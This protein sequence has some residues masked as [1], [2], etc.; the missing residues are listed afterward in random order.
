M[1]LFGISKN[2]PKKSEADQSG[3]LHSY[4]FTSSKGFRGYKKTVLTT[5]NPTSQWLSNADSLISRYG[6]E[7]SNLPVSIDIHTMPNSTKLF[8]LVV[9]DGL[10]IGAIYDH[11][12]YFEE[13]IN[14]DISSIHFSNHIENIVDNG[15]IHPRNRI[16][17]FVQLS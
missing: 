4:R 8:A 17:A 6:D 15:N 14:G 9:V 16:S 7:L 12:P 10:E 2:K 13:I 5:Y 1:G 11:A 3:P